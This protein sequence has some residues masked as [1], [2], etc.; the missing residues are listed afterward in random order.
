M[1]GVRKADRIGGRK[2][3]PWTRRLEREKETQTHDL[4][5]GKFLGGDGPQCQL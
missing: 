4:S 1:W 5:I 2:T 3:G